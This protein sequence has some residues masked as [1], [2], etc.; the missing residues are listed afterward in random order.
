[1]QLI[2]N[3]LTINLFSD[4][5]LY[6]VVEKKDDLIDGIPTL[7]VGLEM[8]K[9]NYPNFNL[10]DMNIDEMTKWTYGP[11]EKRNVYE[12][13][14]SKFIFAALFLGVFRLVFMLKKHERMTKEL[15]ISRDSLLSSEQKMKSQFER[16]EYVVSHDSTTGLINRQEFVDKISGELVTHDSCAFF[17]I[18]ID[19]FKKINDSMGHHYGDEIIKMIADRIERMSSMDA[20]VGRFGGDEFIIAIMDVT[21]EEIESYIEKLRNALKQKFI[22][23]GKNIYL[24]FSTGI[25]LY[26]KDG[27][28]ISDLVVNADLALSRVKISGKDSYA[29]FD[30]EMKREARRKEEI[31][32]TLRRA[33]NENGFEVYFQPKIDLRYGRVAGFEALIRLKDK[34]V[35]PSVFIPIAEE[36]G[37]IITIDRWVTSEVIKRLSQ[38][39][40]MGLDRIPVSVNYSAKQ[41]RDKEYPSYVRELLEKENV[42]PDLLDIE[43]TEGI[44]IDDNASSKGVV[45]ELRQVGVTL[46]MDDFGT[47]YSS[48]NYLNYIDVDYVKLDKSMIDRY[49]EHD[50]EV[51]ACTIALIHSLGLKVVAEGI[52]SWGNCDRIRECG[53]DYIQGNLFGKAMPIDEATKIHDKSVNF[54]HDV[55][56]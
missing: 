54:E 25:A 28:M 7:C 24:N 51:L 14:L 22:V 44:F 20:V 55:I 52:D 10:L 18:D 40:I 9:K 35:G 50:D 27:N 46:S 42:E 11:R 13:R 33:I 45:E 26:P 29:F 37:L 16:L 31:E 19:D 56:R 47:G 8:T 48:L 53:C 32:N 15:S 5:I 36:T 34:S 2:A 49:L 43:I 23:N 21:E 3:I 4:K 17:I 30:E 12:S 41:M 6:N 1:M 38:W 39:K